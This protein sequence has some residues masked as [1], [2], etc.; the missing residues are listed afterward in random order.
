[1]PTPECATQFQKKHSTAEMVVYIPPFA[2]LRPSSQRAAVTFLTMFYT[3]PYQANLATREMGTEVLMAT[4]YD[5]RHPPA[6]ILDPYVQGD[7]IPV[8][9][10]SQSRLRC[11]AAS[12][13]C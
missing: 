10:G 9:G 1:M 3:I 4:C 8:Q 12:L 11:R 5:E 2:F 6:A 13:L 7:C